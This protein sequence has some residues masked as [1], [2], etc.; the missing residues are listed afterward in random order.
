VS[1]DNT[2]ETIEDVDRL[3]PGE[4]VIDADGDPLCLVDTHLGWP[5]RM[6][7]HKAR[8]G[9]VG[10]CSAIERA[11]FPLARAEIAEDFEC[12]HRSGTNEC[13]HCHICGQVVGESRPLFFD[14]ET[15]AM[16]SAAG[17][18]NAR[19]DADHQIGDRP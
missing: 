18:H 16:V 11:T 2:I 7:M 17:R 3:K 1:D 8:K 14:A 6:W 5:Q 10:V 9:F 12:Q 19:V 15:A 13:G 4:W